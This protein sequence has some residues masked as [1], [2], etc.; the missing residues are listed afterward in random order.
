ML[1]TDDPEAN[2]RTARV[3]KRQFPHLKVFARARNRQSLN[4]ALLAF[5]QGRY[6]SAEK[7]AAACVRVVPVSGLAMPSRPA[8]AGSLSARRLFGASSAVRSSVL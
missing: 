1:A 2:L 4:D 8:Q 5:F 3:I 6:A 7:S